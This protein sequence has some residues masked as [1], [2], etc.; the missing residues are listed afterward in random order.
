MSDFYCP[1]GQ[2]EFPAPGLDSKMTG[3]FPGGWF[4]ETTGS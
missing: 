1:A 3:G 2:A 4:C